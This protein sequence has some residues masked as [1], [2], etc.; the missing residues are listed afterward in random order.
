[1]RNLSQLL[2][3][4]V[5]LLQVA[6]SSSVSAS[7][8]AA[9]AA[10]EALTDE[11]VAEGV[12]AEWIYTV[13][14]ED[15]LW[16]LAEKFCGTHSRWLDIAEYNNLPDP[17]NL[18]AGTRL[19]IPLNWLIEEPAVVRVVYARGD[20]RI[21]HASALAAVTAVATAGNSSAAAANNPQEM[22]ESF[23]KPFTE[24][25]GAELGIGS[26]ITTGQ[27]SYANVAFADGS[28]MQIGPDSEVQF[29]TLSAYKDTGMV[30]S[31]IRINR[32]STASE[33][34]HQ[35]GPGSVYRISTPLGVAA[36]RGTEFRTRSVDGANF[37]ETTGGSVDFI[38]STGISNVAGGFGLKADATG[39]SVEALI[40]PPRITAAKTYGVS[41]NLVWEAQG[42][43]AHYLVRVYSGPD[44]SEV[45][46]QASVPDTQYA[47]ASIGP[48]S[49][50]LGVRGIAASGLQGLEAIQALTVR[51]MLAAPA[52][53][54]VQQ[55]RRTPE[56]LVKWEGVAGASEYRV[57]A[58]PL[59]GGEPIIETTNATEQQLTGLARGKYSVSVEA[60]APDFVSGVS[61]PEQRRV[62]GPF[63]WGWG[64]LLLPFAF[65]L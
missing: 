5:L 42:D 36:V 43:A 49:Y 4:F 9:A 37:V 46:A 57:V 27:Q 17:T 53:V 51:N 48:G 55:V 45:L 12:A 20:V 6:V 65:V 23:V 10:A 15:R 31:R 38:A 24:I 26:K 16:G 3:S 52:K 21:V 13:R 40:D 11:T 25:V 61:E 34:E 22:L 47:L 1:M 14:P 39:T 8:A 63:N 30:D 2:L 58:T 59:A 64:A 7:E 44:L 35:D 54:K 60:N 19:R 28:T 33:V 29:D 32:G 56:L 50:V 18:A 62:R 41:D